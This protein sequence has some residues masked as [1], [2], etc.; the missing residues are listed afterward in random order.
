MVFDCCC[1]CGCLNIGFGII[2][3]LLLSDFNDCT[4]CP[5]GVF[6]LLCFDFDLI[7]MEFVQ[8]S[9]WL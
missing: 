8:I 4:K 1:V 7:L 9:P 3:F 5:E 6:E 2:L